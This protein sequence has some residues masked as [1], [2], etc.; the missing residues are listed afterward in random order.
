MPPHPTA[1]ARVPALAHPAGATQAPT[2][3]TWVAASIW[4]KRRLAALGHG[5]TGGPGSS[6]RA[7]VGAPRPLAAAWQRVAAQQGAAGGEGS[8][9]ARGQARASP[10]LA[11]RAKTRRAGRSQPLPARRGPIPKGHGTPRPWGSAAGKERLGQAAVH[12]VLEPLVARDVLPGTDGFRPGRGGQE[13]LRAVDQW[14]KA[15][16]PWGGAVDVARDCDPSPQAPWRARVAE[17]VRE[18]TRLDLRPRCLEQERREGR[19]PWPPLAGGPQGAVRSPLLSPL[20]VP[21]VERV[22]APAGYQRGR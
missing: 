15:G 2:P 12:R 20:S 3:W 7:T 10:S 16:S 19:P 9:I 8:R 18:G 14:R 13:A 4:T 21:P 11:A 6:R 1:P 17:K 5:G 22:G